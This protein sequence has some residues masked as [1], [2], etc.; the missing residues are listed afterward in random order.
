MNEKVET[1]QASVAAKHEYWGQRIAEW[2]RSGQSQK[3]FCAE[4]SLVLSTFP[5]WCA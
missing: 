2:K 5:W 3:A 1:V 4:R